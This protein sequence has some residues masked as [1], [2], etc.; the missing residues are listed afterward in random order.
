MNP[1]NKSVPK[2]RFVPICH[3]C[4]IQGHIRPHCNKMKNHTKNQRRKRNSSLEKINK[5]S[6]WVRKHDLRCN[7]VLPAL[8]AKDSHVWYLDI[9]CFRHMTG[10]MSMPT[11]L[12]GFDGGNV[13]FGDG[14]KSKIIIKK[15]QYLYQGC[16][17][18]GIFSSLMV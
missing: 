17:I 18:F 12:K 11:S 8:T 4:G 13:N 1:K 7:V 10:K 3:F 6:I 2:P 16:L 5:K 14:N 9:T 15:V